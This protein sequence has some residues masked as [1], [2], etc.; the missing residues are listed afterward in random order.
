MSNEEINKYK[1]LYS[2]LVSAYAELHNDTMVFVKTRGR[3][4]GYAT[5]QHLRIVERLAKEL[6]RQGLLAHKEH[7]ANLKEEK[8]LKREEKVKRKRT[9][10]M[11]RKPKKEIKNDNN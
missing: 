10:P 7:V 1:E 11:P 9:T 5:R 6:K 4:V 3:D 8:K 2:Q